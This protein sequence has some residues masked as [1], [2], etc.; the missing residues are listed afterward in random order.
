MISWMSCWTPAVGPHKG[1]FPAAV[2]FILL[3]ALWWQCWCG[4]A[5]WHRLLSAHDFVCKSEVEHGDFHIR[6][7]CGYIFISVLLSLNH[8]QT[9]WVQCMGLDMQKRGCMWADL[10]AHICHSYRG[11]LA[12]HL[13]ARSNSNGWWTSVTLVLLNWYCVLPPE[14]KLICTTTC[15]VFHENIEALWMFSANYNALGHTGCCVYLCLHSLYMYLSSCY[16]Q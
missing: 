8:Q 12:T 14:T 6:C 4:R 9:S 2:V 5:R 15:W 1:L 3:F 7:K 13:F 16:F 10:G 11:N